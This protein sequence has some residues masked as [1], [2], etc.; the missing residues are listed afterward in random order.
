LPALRLKI[1]MDDKRRILLD[2]PDHAK[3]IYL[4]RK[5]FQKKELKKLIK[6]LKLEAF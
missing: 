3:K 4:K 2:L 6:I 1:A 5:S